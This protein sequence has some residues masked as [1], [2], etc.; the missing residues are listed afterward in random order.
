MRSQRP[1]CYSWLVS[2]WV[3]TWR[4]RNWW[5]LTNPK[6]NSGKSVTKIPGCVNRRPLRT[7]LRSSLQPIDRGRAV[8]L[9]LL[10]LSP[11]SP[12]RR[13]RRS[14]SL[15]HGQ[16][17]LDTPGWALTRRPKAPP[18]LLLSHKLPKMGWRLVSGHLQ[19]T[20]GSNSTMY[21]CPDRY[22]TSFLVR[23]RLKSE[24]FKEEMNDEIWNYNNVPHLSALNGST[25]CGNSK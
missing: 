4:G 23:S 11:C 15:R 13:G 17:T 24:V 3:V 12:R 14:G 9:A 7:C 20:R 22:T 18:G 1:V 8:G 19:N 5:I 25:W 2:T 10:S 21:C 6:I 16:R